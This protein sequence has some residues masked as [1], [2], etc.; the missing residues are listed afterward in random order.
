MTSEKGLRTTQSTYSP[1]TWSL[2]QIGFW[3]F[4]EGFL[5][6]L[7]PGSLKTLSSRFVYV[8]GRVR[9]GRESNGWD[10]LKEVVSR[11]CGWCVLWGSGVWESVFR[12]VV[13]PRWECD[14][15]RVKDS[16]GWEEAW[17]WENSSNSIV[18]DG[19]ERGWVL[20]RWESDGES[21][22]FDVISKG[23]SREPDFALVG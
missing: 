16:K 17:G 19:V 4:L 12:V 3:Q 5:L 9:Q 15:E 20:G 1:K 6:T 13:G 10:C 2:A 7:L 14:K 22:V 11:S 23:E 18:G 8:V 21:K